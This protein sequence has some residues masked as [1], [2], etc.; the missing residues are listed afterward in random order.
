M[1]SGR[2]K[3]EC[4]EE[5]LGWT[6]EGWGGGSH[7]HIDAIPGEIGSGLLWGEK[8]GAWVSQ[9]RPGMRVTT[10]LPP[11]DFQNGLKEGGLSRD[12]HRE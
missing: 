11:R 4:K 7:T 1:S 3:G 12:Q 10:L 9:A 6:R 8:K 2:P 5:E